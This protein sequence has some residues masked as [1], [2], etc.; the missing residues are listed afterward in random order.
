MSNLINAQNIN[1]EFPT[2]TIFKNLQIGINTGDRIGV[3]GNNGV[4]KSTLFG[5]LTKTLTPNSGQITSRSNLQIGTLPQNNTL[6]PNKT[7][8]ETVVGNTPEHVWASNPKTREI[9]ENL[10]NDVPWETQIK[11]LS[12]GQQKRT[13]LAKLLVEDWDCLLLDEPTNHLDIEG[14]TWLANHLKKRWNPNN[15]ALLVITHDRWFLDEISNTTWE[16]NNNKI[17]N[18]EGGYAAYI[19]QRVERNRLLETTENKRQNLLRKELAWLRRG[20]PARTTKPKFRIDAANQL[21]EKEPPARDTVSLTQMATTRLG[22]QV[23]ELTNVTLQFDNKTILENIQWNLAPG[24]RTGILGINGAGKSTLLALI[25]GNLQPTT[26]TRKQGKTVKIATLSQN[27]AEVDLIENQKISEI[28]SRYKTSYNTAGKD[29][30]P[31][32]LLERLG[33]SSNQL[34]TPIKNLSGGQRRRLQLLLILLE[35]PNVLIL[36][37]PTNDMDTDMLAAMEDLLDSWPGTLIV[38]SHD[39]YFMERVT[40]QQYAIINKTLTH[41]PAGI[42]QYLQLTQKKP[43]NTNNKNKTSQKQNK[44]PAT[45][46]R[47]TQKN[48]NTIDKKISKLNKTISNKE[49]EISQ[50]NNTNIETLNQLTLQL[51]ELKTELTQLENHWLELNETLE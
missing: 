23:V 46:L 13:A 1:L 2:K 8:T 3:V 32:Q 40:D 33:F 44:L 36:D 15:A 16:I 30:T 48:I 37:E 22:K 10:I 5:L 25:T 39:R 51:H 7:V 31:G 4:G 28:V 26:G 29:L 42:D 19:L 11:N 18:Y 12:G 9:L 21:I 20:A 6:N 38:V 47:Q 14:I 50:I 45:Q 17:E 34:A 41:L 35:E 27:L 49:T 43:N 24:E